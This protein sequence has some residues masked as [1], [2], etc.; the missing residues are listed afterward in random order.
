MT[1]HQFRLCTIFNLLYSNCNYLGGLK[2]YVFGKNSLE[3]PITNSRHVVNLKSRDQK[4]NPRRE[5]NLVFIHI[6]ILLFFYKLNDI[7]RSYAIS[8][9][10]T[11][12]LKYDNW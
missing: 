3:N 4:H 9:D 7:Y 2:G 5:G 6:L 10:K 1:H 8:K 12:K 11:K